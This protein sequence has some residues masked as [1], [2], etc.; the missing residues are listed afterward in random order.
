MYGLGEILRWNLDLQDFQVRVA[1][2]LDFQILVRPDY[3]IFEGNR[4]ESELYTQDRD[5]KSRL[6]NVP[7]DYSNQ[8]F[9]DFNLVSKVIS[10]FGFLP[11]GP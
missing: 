1:Q 11:L 9:P 2:D 3:L 7:T 4:D 5:L 6:E 8:I 10:A